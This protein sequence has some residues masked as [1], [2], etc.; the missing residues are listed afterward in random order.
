MSSQQE[1]LVEMIIQSLEKLDK[2][3]PETDKLASYLYVADKRL[4]DYLAE[5]RV[6]L[7][8]EQPSQD[9]RIQF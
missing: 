5:L 7:K 1:E 9:Q 3:D 8:C 4:S 6:F 2:N